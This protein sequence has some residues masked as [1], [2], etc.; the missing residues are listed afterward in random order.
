MYEVGELAARQ[1][2]CERCKVTPGLKLHLGCGRPPSVSL[3]YEEAGLH[4]QQDDGEVLTPFEAV[5]AGLSPYPG[6]GLGGLTK[7]W[8]WCPRWF[9]AFNEDA[10]VG[11]VPIDLLFSDLQYYIENGSVAAVY[12]GELTPFAVDGLRYYRA[13][14]AEADHIRAERARKERERNG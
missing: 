11:G 14:K 12:P 5:Q 13:A 6:V 2:D 8:P 3:P 4:R 10:D 1:I 9:S 7:D